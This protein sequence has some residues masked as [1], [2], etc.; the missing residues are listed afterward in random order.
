MTRAF[1]FPGR[2]SFLLIWA[3]QMVSLLGSGLTSF[4]LGVWIYQRTD[5][6]MLLALNMFAYALPQVLLSPV[7]GALVDRWDRRVAMIVSDAGASLTALA[8]ALLYFSGRLAPGNVYLCTAVMSGFVTLQWPAWSAA[9]TL[10]VPKEHLGRASGMV[11]AVDAVATLAA[12]AFAGAL[13]ARI[14]V[15]I[16]VLA[17]AASYLI[18]ILVMVFFVRVPR[19]PRSAESR[20]ASSSLWS[21]MR[22]GWSFIAVRPGLLGLLLFFTVDNFFSTMVTPLLQP[23]I[24]DAW[25]PEV[26]GLVSSIMGLGMLAGTL[27]MSAWGGPRRRM[28]GLL[29]AGALGGLAL[30][31]AGLRPSIALI[32]SAVFA[33]SFLMPTMAGCSQAIWQVKVPPDLQGRVFSVRRMIAWSATPVAF[34]VAGPLADQVFK[35]LLVEGGPLAS[36]V[37]R[38]LGV[39]PGRGI[40]LQ[41]IVLGILTAVASVLA[42]FVRRIRRVELDLPDATPGTEG[43]WSWLPEL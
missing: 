23:M 15:G 1:S 7:A 35:P 42:L 12:P 36:S 26:F 20:Q 37:G 41:I 14:G 43:G 22:M 8:V 18:A 39:G 24:L 16:L 29:G 2:R 5:S 27:V 13:Y 10:L 33:Y 9:T 40:G 11:Q 38:V 21:E 31:V 32:A 4:A 6:V 28:Y 17:D 34:V 3:G 25:S 30:A 19:P